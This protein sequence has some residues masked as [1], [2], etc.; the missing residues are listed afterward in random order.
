MDLHTYTCSDPLY[1]LSVL[2]LTEIVVQTVSKLS[3][4]LSHSGPQHPHPHILSGYS[5]PIQSV[6]CQVDSEENIFPCIVQR[7]SSIVVQ[8]ECQKYKRCK[9]GMS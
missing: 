4:L 3:L 7:D 9:K 6:Y 2:P 8:C 5:F 1:T